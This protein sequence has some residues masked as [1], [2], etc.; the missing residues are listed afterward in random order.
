[1]EILLSLLN[2]PQDKRRDLAVLLNTPLSAEVVETDEDGNAV[3][4]VNGE[5]YPITLKEGALAS[6]EKLTV[7]FLKDTMGRLSLQILPAESA[8][9]RPSAV[10]PGKDS[11]AEFLPQASETRVDRK[12]AA[13]VR[14]LSDVSTMLKGAS[15]D[16]N[17]PVT[18]FKAL[19][20]AALSPASRPFA[21]DTVLHAPVVGEKESTALAFLKPRLEALARE[22]ASL[23]TVAEPIRQKVAEI[24]AAVREVVDAAPKEALKQALARVIS[25]PQTL[26][27]RPEAGLLKM[28][29]ETVYPDKTVQV[30][31]PEGQRLIL[32]L[33]A[34]AAPGAVITA[35]L[36]PDGPLFAPESEILIR[37]IAQPVEPAVAARV[38]EAAVDMGL[39]P[40]MPRDL[41]EDLYPVAEKIQAFLKEE[42]LLPEEQRSL[43]RSLLLLHSKKI[44]FDVIKP[45]FALYRN[46]QTLA[47]SLKEIVHAILTDKA[48]AGP[49][50]LKEVLKEVM[51]TLKPLAEVALLDHAETK[52]GDV[53]RRAFE[54]SGLFLENKLL[55]AHADK[56]PANALLRNDLKAA[57]LKLMDFLASD[58][59]APETRQQVEAEAGKVLSM[60]EA[61]QVKSLSD[62]QVHNVIIPFVCA[63]EQRSAVIT[64]ARRGKSRKVDKR[65]T[66]LRI[67]VC[68]GALGEVEVR[69]QIR[70]NVLWILFLLEKGKYVRMFS[71]N[72]T[73][74]SDALISLGYSIGRM[75]ADLLTAAN[76]DTDNGLNLLFTDK[77]VKGGLDVTA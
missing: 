30:S 5:K 65:N 33:P 62:Q 34:N 26:P 71:E 48:L 54:N 28:K 43:V 37:S 47:S 31:L 6:G 14:L 21:S 2:L 52:R 27:A 50:A 70:N 18:E 4:V 72:W 63:G 10:I 20:Q 55:K 73:E 15:L 35:L 64:V 56:V 69:V 51:E 22:T 25:P 58:T 9:A 45:E 17:R 23:E 1:M 29:V 3:I 57:L 16:E 44:G 59:L 39:L 12:T 76:R 61:L 38:M 32:S 24:T 19:I 7:V 77:A 53:I 8:P 74:L 40:S 60:I 41:P 66:G 68:P 11:L 46:V 42:P 49:Q 13:L 67:R 36:K 75:Q